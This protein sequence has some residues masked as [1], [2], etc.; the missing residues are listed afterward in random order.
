M[1]LAA[2]MQ[3]FAVLFRVH[4]FQSFDPFL[5]NGQAMNPTHRCCTHA[6]MA[7]PHVCKFGLFS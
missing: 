1:N 3:N 6:Q 4:K 7:Q 2:E 5:M